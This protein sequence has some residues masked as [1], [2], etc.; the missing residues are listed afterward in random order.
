MFKLIVAVTIFFLFYLAVVTEMVAASIAAIMGSSFMVLF[1]VMSFPE[2]V[3]SIDFEVIFL[4]I[5]MMMMVSVI[6]E[7]GL[8]EWIAIKIAQ[9]VGGY[10]IPLLMLL[11]VMTAFLSA[12]LDNV[13]TVLVVVPVTILLAKQLDISPVPFVITQAI[14]SNIGGAATLIGD[15]PNILIASYSNFTFSD[16]IIHLTPIAI[17]NMVIFS[18]LSWIF[19]RKKL[20]VTRYKRALIMDMDA[21]RAIA[22]KSALKRSLT[23][24]LLVIVGFLMQR[25]WGLNPAMTAL[26]GGSLMIVLTGKH[27][28]KVF[29]KIEWNTILFFAGLFVIVGGVSK[30][31]VLEMIG[32]LILKITRGNYESTSMLLLWISGLVSSVFDNVPY[33]ATIAPIIR[34]SIIP[35]VSQ[36]QPHVPAELVKNALW[37]SLALGTCLGGNGT[38][39]GASANIVSADISNRSGY[40]ITFGQFTKYGAIFALSTLFASAAYIWI[41]YLI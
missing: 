12:F 32:S 27:P 31:G 22:K 4:L 11:G 40:K 16:F 35:A 17:I 23:V 29:L 9:L 5:G 6:A 15:P 36:L 19:F 30:V 2:S 21:R 24:F 18:L 33:T 37:W 34:D 8:F 39:I 28:E 26:L 14:A 7:T 1:G 38:L 25:S 10:P 41:R 3:A 13:T 20:E